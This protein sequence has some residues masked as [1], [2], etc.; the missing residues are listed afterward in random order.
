MKMRLTLISLLI[1]IASSSLLAQ[2]VEY[3][4]YQSQSI[5]NAWYEST[6]KYWNLKTNTQATYTLNVKVE[7]NRVTK[8]DLGDNGSLHS[9]MNNEGYI[10]SGGNLFFELDSNNNVKAATTTV[11]ITGNNI[12]TTWKI[13]IE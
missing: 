12:Y 11:T 5:K 13:R 2:F 10:Y 3:T 1:F 4:P 8:I 7:S 6:I 9:G